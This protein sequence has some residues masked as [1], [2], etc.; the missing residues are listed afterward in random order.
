VFAAAILEPLPDDGV[1]PLADGAAYG[2]ARV[3]ELQSH[4]PFRSFAQLRL[5][6]EPL[7]E[8]QTGIDRRLRGIVLHRALQRFWAELQSQQ[9]LLRLDT[10]DCD[11]KVT[12]AIDQ[13][14]TEVLPAEC[15]QRSLAL[16]RDWQRRA[17]GHLLALERARPAFTVVET[18]RALNGRIGG[19]DLRLRVDRVDRI[20]DELVVI[21]YKSGAVRKAQWRGARMEAPQLPLY[22]VL[23]PRHPAGIAIAELG[24]DRADFTGI[25]RD[26][27]LIAGLQAARDFE[28][29]EERENGFDWPVIKEHWYAWLERLARDHAAGHAE[30]DPKLGTDTCRHCHLDALCR[31]A[32]AVPDEP[33]AEEG[34][35]DD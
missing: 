11:R 6:A 32:S 18:E 5:R 19:L 21:D 12:A 22:A 9:A 25:C 28:L 23:H 3:L 27:G 29:T 24:S 2:G 30:V 26:Q 16:E 34:G 33:G 15:G 20:G 31:V 35:D 10:A 14:L 8:P 4:C 7:A 13:S 17:I 1:P